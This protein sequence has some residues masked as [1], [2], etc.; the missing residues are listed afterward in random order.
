MYCLETK[1]AKEGSGCFIIVGASKRQ[2]FI[3]KMSSPKG[4]EMTAITESQFPR[5]AAK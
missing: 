2:F 4:L 1:C 5:A 3:S